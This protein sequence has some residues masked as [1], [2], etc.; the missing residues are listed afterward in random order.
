VINDGRALAAPGDGRPP[1][2]RWVAGTAAVS[3]VL[4][5]IGF[6]AVAGWSLRA[7]TLQP[8]DD[9]RRQGQL[10]H[11]DRA[12]EAGA[13]ERGQQLFPEGFFFQHALTG[14]AHATAAAPGDEPALA[15]ARAALRAVDSPEGAARFQVSNPPNGA[16]HAGWSLLLAVQ[17]SRLSGD[18]ADATVV[19]ERARP[20]LASVQ[21]RLDS[22]GS[23][24]LDS[25]PGQSWPVDSVVLVAALAQAD[26]EL[27]VDGAASLVSRWRGAVRQRADPVSGLLPHRTRADGTAIDGARGSSQSVIQTFWPDID[28]PGAADSYRRFTEHFVDRC[29]GLVGA[30]EYPHGQAGRGDVDSGPLVDGCSAS[31]TAVTLA[32]ARRN[33]DLPLAATL[34]REAEL[35]WTPT[36]IAGRRYAGGLLPV[37]DA[38]LAWARAQ[39]VGT[40]TPSDTPQ[41]RWAWWVAVPA[42]ASGLCGV[43]AARAVRRVRA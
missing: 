29:A 23:P 42:V 18:P 39:P 38:F 2:R 10:V 11:L 1:R 30:R 35:A 9:S 22:G 6:A 15:A 19:R 7:A 43:V 28:P 3:A 4:V 24:F 37:A 34:D 31:A 25:Y 14:L 33:G 16:F 8:L 17:I 20:A 5:G 13:A 21:A 27:G 36:P 32:A 12:L 40:G 26:T 41:V